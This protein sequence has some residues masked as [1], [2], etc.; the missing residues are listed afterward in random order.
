MSE[1]RQQVTVRVPATTANLGPGFDCLGLALGLYNEV[2]VERGEGIAVTIEGE[3]KGQLQED[4]ENL[5]VKAARYLSEY[6]GRQL[7]GLWVRQVNE[8]PVGSG[9]GSSAAA[10]VGGLLAADTLLGTGLSRERLLALATIL[11]GHGDNAA[12]AIYGG[13]VLANGSGGKVLVEQ[14]PLPPIRLVVVLPAFELPTSEA[15]AA[16]PEQ[17]S[18]QDALFNAGRAA[19]L[20]WALT[21]G[22]QEQLRVAMQDRLH[23]PYRLRLIPGMEEAFAVAEAAGA[24][25]ALSGAGPS[26]IAIAP[27]EP[28][29]LV[30]A[31]RATFRRA[32]L[33]SRHW[34]L[35]TVN[36]GAMVKQHASYVQ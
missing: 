18:L 13:L 32:G 35:P 30:E 17:V 23:Q 8:I 20:V 6:T 29:V 34:I 19:L 24:A 5:V 21:Q 11:E 7:P 1:G 31:L 4:E 2:T 36:H 3:G 12:A 14:L 22:K 28:E 26:L 9:L 25:V 16:L 27:R 33:E 10:V 15:R